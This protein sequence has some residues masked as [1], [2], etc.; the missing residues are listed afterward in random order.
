M[1]KINADRSKI[2]EAILKARPKWLERAAERTAANRAA[3]RH[4]GP[5]TGDIWS[6]IK[7]VF[8]ELQLRKCAYCERSFPESPVE[9]DV[10][11]YRPKRRVKAWQTKSFSF[12][13]QPDP[14]GTGYYL[15]AYDPGNYL[16]ACETCNRIRK[17]D[18]FPVFGNRE[19][20][21]SDP[22]ILAGEKPLLINPIDVNDDDPEELIEFNGLIPRPCAQGGPAYHRAIATIE[23]FDLAHRDEL[24][25][26]RA[27]VVVKLWLAYGVR[28]DRKLGPYAQTILTALCQPGARHANC[29]RSFLRLCRDDEKTARGVHA[30]IMPLWLSYQAGPGR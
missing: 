16:A 4:S 23:L 14:A 10:D 13:D 19:M 25:R 7:A 17:G 30:Q 5:S 9:I 1:I 26:E 15:L 3:R 6:E 21:S 8:V 18:L 27:D 22:Y 2:D 24:L 12:T 11:H 20:D 29:A 28:S